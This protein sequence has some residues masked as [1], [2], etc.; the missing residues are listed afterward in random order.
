MHCLP[1]VRDKLFE[2]LREVGFDVVEIDPEGYRSPYDT[3]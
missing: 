3:S 2:G 1:E